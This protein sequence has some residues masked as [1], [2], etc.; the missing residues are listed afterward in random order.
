MDDR[1]R[2]DWVDDK[3]FTKDGLSVQVRKLPL[4]WPRYSIAVGTLVNENTL[5]FIPLRAA[6]KGKIVLDRVGAALAALIAEAEDY[7][8]SE[9]Q[10][11]ED[12]RIEE[13]LHDEARELNRDKP[14]AKVGL[15][16]GPNSGKTARKKANKQQ[17]RTP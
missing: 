15:S 16:G 13:R 14:R 7:V 17:R 11:L 12:Q 4:R 2:V 8:W 5:R 1:P 9:L 6:G 3:R 10:Y